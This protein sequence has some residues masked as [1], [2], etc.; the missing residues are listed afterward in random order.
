VILPFAGGAQVGVADLAGNARGVIVAGETS[1]DNPRVAL[2]DPESGAVIRSAELSGYPL[3]GIR[4]AGGDLDSD[5]RD[6]IVVTS[7]FGGDGRVHILDANLNETR[8]FLAYDWVGAGTNVAVAKR[9]GFPIASEARTV[10]LKARK[11]TQIVIARFREAGGVIV[12]LNATINWG[13]GTTGVGAV[14]LRSGPIY[15]VRAAKRYRAA[16]RYAV[17][18]TVTAADGRTSVAHSRAIVSRR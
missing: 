18:V 14:V 2:I 8:S 12:H 10:K 16:G 4:I 6:E 1:G 7:G 11:R 3:S 9:F 17:T 15:E 13:D 5:G